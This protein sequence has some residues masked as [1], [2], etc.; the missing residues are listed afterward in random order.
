M[1][2]NIPLFIDGE[3][4]QSSSKEKKEILD[5]STQEILGY[6]PYASDE[7]IEQAV[8]V[9]KKSFPNLERYSYS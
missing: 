9:A 8:S 1:K 6:V 5:P 3:F 4:V 2:E 7:E